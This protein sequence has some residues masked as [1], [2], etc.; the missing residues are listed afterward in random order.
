V[1]SRV[2]SRWGTR[3]VG[4][5]SGRYWWGWRKVLWRLGAAWSMCDGDVPNHLTCEIIIRNALCS[6]E[7]WGRGLCWQLDLNVETCKYSIL[8][9]KAISNLLQTNLNW[10]SDLQGTR[11]W[12]QVSKEMANDKQIRTQGSAVSGCTFTK[13]AP[14]LYYRRK[15]RR[16][17]EYI[18]Q[19]TLV[20]NTKQNKKMHT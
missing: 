17:G 1:I 7:R 3:T 4:N 8:P 14:V 11:F 6:G 10:V 5:G 15:T 16:L 9:Y 13:Q 19:G 2:P 18:H 20:L 12:L